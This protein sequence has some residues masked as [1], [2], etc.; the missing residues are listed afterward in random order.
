MYKQ[1]ETL[2]YWTCVPYLIRHVD[3]SKKE[4]ADGVRTCDFK[5]RLE[6]PQR[7]P[8]TWPPSPIA[9]N[10]CPETGAI[11]E[12]NV[13]TFQTCKMAATFK[14]STITKLCQNQV[15]FSYFTSNSVVQYMALHSFRCVLSQE[16]N[17]HMAAVLF[18]EILH[19]EFQTWSQNVN[20]I[21]HLHKSINYFWITLLTASFNINYVTLFLGKLYPPP[22]GVTLVSQ[23]LVAPSLS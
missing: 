14:L 12:S 10:Q 1:Y 15:C 6:R 18:T 20:I 13:S 8:A 3:C 21:A 4:V 22:P 2:K 16:P 23:F 19:F 17:F 11:S 7:A 5:V 9:Q